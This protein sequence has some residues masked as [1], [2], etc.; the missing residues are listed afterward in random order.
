MNSP[1]EKFTTATTPCVGCETTTCPNG[2][3]SGSVTRSVPLTGTP[4]VAVIDRSKATGGSL[5]ALTS[6]EIAPTFDVRTPSLTTNVK[7][8][9]PLRPPFNLAV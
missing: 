4:G 5:T 6:T 8:S 7:V 3:P 1:L 2:V 9:L